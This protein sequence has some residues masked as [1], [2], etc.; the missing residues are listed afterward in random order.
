[1]RPLTLVSLA[2]ALGAASLVGGCISFGGGGD[3]THYVAAGV[4]YNGY[5]DDY[6][7]PIA[8]GYWGPDGVF[9]YATSRGGPY[10]RDDDHHIQAE[11]TP[12]HH[13]IHG[14]HVDHPADGEHHDH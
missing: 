4:D 12:G 14:H 7:G 11:A 3:H 8:D 10:R 1:M 13:N 9:V 2:A 6:Y 5:Y